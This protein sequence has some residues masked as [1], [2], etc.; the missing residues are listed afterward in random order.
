VKVGDLVKYKW[1]T[2]AQKRRAKQ[3]GCPG[4]SVGIIIDI[5]S[6]SRA[7]QG[8]YNQLLVKFVDMQDPVRA[9]QFNLEKVV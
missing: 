7:R 5:I 8:K 1:I 3:F 2:M 4:D 6:E 9:T